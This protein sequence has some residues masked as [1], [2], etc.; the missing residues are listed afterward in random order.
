M[1]LSRALTA[2]F[3]WLL[4]YFSCR[5]ESFIP[6]LPIFQ[7][8]K[9]PLRSGIEHRPR[10]PTL[11]L[12]VTQDPTEDGSCREVMALAGGLD[13]CS[14]DDT[15]ICEVI[16][17]WEVVDDYES[18][19]RL[20]EIKRRV[21]WLWRCGFSE[22]IHLWSWYSKEFCVNHKSRPG[23]LLINSIAAP[24]LNQINI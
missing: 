18:V 17:M 13:D 1:Q 14:A 7:V 21:N 24:S 10:L 20:L 16:L 6:A 15:D 4:I 22:M 5:S 23:R 8:W 3:S 19:N 11:S 9:P 12:R 2:A